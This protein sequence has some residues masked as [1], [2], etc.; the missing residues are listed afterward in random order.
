MRRIAFFLF[1]SLASLCSAA[2]ATAERELRVGLSADVSS[3]DPHFAA[4]ASNVNISSHV[5]DT[6]MQVDADAKLIPGLA[7]S[8]RTVD[9]TTWEFK[10]RRGVLFHDG[11]E[12]TA[13][14]VVFSLDRPLQ[15]SNRPSGFQSYIKSIVAKEAVDR[16]T[17]RLRT[18]KPYALLPYELVSVFIVSRQAAANAEAWDFDNGRA[19]IGTGPYRFLRFLRGDRIELQRNET[20][21]GPRPQWE[22]VS[23]RLITSDPARIAGLLS[24]GLDL[25]DNVPPSDVTRLQKDSRFALDRKVSWRTIFYSLDQRPQASASITDRAGRPLDPNPLSD[26]RVRLALSKAINRSAIADRVM[27][28]LAVPTANIVSPAIAGHEPALAAQAYD[29]E[30]AR[31]LLR[32]AGYPDGFT[33]T[34]HAPNNRYVNDEQVAQAVAQMLSRVGIAARVETLPLNIY[35]SKARAQNFPF[36]MLGWGSFSGTLALRS[37]LMTH[38]TQR[39]LGA[40]NWGRYSNAAFDRP[41]LQALETFDD[42]AREQ[43]VRQ[44]VRQAYADTAIV[45]LDHQIAMWAM[46]KDLRYTARTDEFTFAFDVHTRQ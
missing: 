17:V 32:E 41:V 22:R 25:I 26:P 18:A 44:A 20:F 33:L 24:G 40:W 42:S 31:R 30:G 16:Y 9:D 21:W 43:L 11:S 34:V 5:F 19:M 38:D 3:M 2:P 14:D 36:A 29:P 1:I 7:E 37:L 46:R 13:E 27:E 15:F 4:L 39:G 8:W 35:F 28:G 6:L 12:L 10:L 23:F 45:P